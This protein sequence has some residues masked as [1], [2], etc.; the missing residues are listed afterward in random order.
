MDL[1]QSTI[2]YFRDTFGTEPDVVARTPGRVNIIGEHTD[3]NQGYVLPIAIDRS[4]VVAAGKR[5]DDLLSLTTIDMQS[6]VQV[7]LSRIEFNTNQQWANY[8]MGVAKIF[9]ERGYRL[10][11][12]N[13]C[14][15]GTIPIGSGL[16]SS[17]ALEVACAIA[18][19]AL[20]DLPLTMSEIIDISHSAESEFVGVQCGIMDQFAVLRAEQNHALF[21]DCHSME[22][23]QVPY[24]KKVQLIVCDTGI[25]RE[26]THSAYNERRR[27][28][29][30]AV[31]IIAQD[32]PGI[33]S[34]RGISWSEF[35]S[36][37][38]K[39]PT[40]IKKRVRHVLS[41]NQRVLQSV[42]AMKRNDLAAL[43]ELMTES[44]LSLRD[45]YDVSCRELDAFVDIAI[46]LEGVYG[47]RMTGA[48]FGGSAIC[49]I[50]EDRIDSL[51]ELL[52]SEYPKR[53]GRSL[54][55]YLASP[56]DGAIVMKSKDSMTPVSLA[57]L[58]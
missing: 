38:K 57:Q 54:V 17:A 35:Q 13:V 43:G 19:A 8:P 2:Q 44:H 53:A 5:T 55:V 28:C 14:I 29:E 3:Y 42:E 23:S 50:A 10:G 33:R 40:H 30:E 21:L 36:V 39:I 15:R 16:S 25:R 41:E 45:D 56:S 27:E 31:R 58:A 47:A 11:G 4:M 37:E 46:S 1:I 7:P 32:I 6:S 26:L 24:P 48:G 52:R 12:A 18:L 9:L 20:N 34:L 22:Y 49:L 51:I